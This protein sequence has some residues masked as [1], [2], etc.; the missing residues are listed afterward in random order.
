[1]RG[2]ISLGE[3]LRCFVGFFFFF[4]FILLYHPEIKTRALRW[5]VRVCICGVS[6]D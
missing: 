1:M 4:N 3:P 2:H 5:T 6:I